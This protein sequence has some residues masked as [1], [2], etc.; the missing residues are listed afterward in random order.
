[1]CNDRNSSEPLEGNGDFRS[2]EC[3]EILKEADIVVTNPPFSLFREFVAQL[4]EYGKKFLVIGNTNAITYKEIFRMIKEDKIRTGY[5]NFNVGM[6]FEVPYSW[7]KYHH[8]DENGNKLARVSTS[9]WWTNL[10]VQK[11]KEDLILYKKYYGNEEEYPWYENYNAI[12][13]SKVSDIPM[14][15]EG[16]MGVPITFIDKYNPEQFEVIDLNP[17]FF[18]V[19][20]R[21]YP[22][23]S[24][25][26]IEGKKDPYARVLI[27][28]KRL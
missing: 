21:G 26:S 13:V 27:K 3:I 12:E 25:L 5:T 16:I 14:D 19:I 11:H 8:I 7:E 20:E 2:K 6:F 28:N 17:H 23:P 9:C 22:K 1:L 10:E 15:F 4:E 24:Q 18:T